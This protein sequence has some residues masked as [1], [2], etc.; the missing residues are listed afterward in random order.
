MSTRDL[1]PQ[2]P[3]SETEDAL[4]S[5]RATARVGRTNAV[6][7]PATMHIGPWLHETAVTILPAVIALALAFGAWEAGIE[8]RD[9]K[10]Y[11]VPAPSAVIP[12]LFEDPWFFTREGLKTLE[13]AM[14]GF[15]AGT[16]VAL[17]LATLMS[18]ARVLERSI[19][20]LAILVKVT[21]IVAIAPLLT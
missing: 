20:P 12:R 8:I 10:P 15:L 18:Q 4:R 6:A 14:L 19:F 9:V 13:A 3:V 7:P 1:A 11:L 5:A 17:V 21:P 2:P 16:G